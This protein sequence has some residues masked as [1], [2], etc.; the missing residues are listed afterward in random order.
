MRI[1]GTLAIFGASICVFVSVMPAR[2]EAQSESQAQ[3]QPATP[4]PEARAHYDAGMAH[5]QARAF[6]EAARAF[7]AARAIEPRPEWLFAEA[8]AT[9]L[10]G[11]CPR[12]VRLYQEF[13]ATSPPPPQVQATALALSRCERADV[14]PAPSTPEKASDIAAADSGAAVTNRVRPSYR[15][16]DGVAATAAPR[17]AGPS[18]EEVHRPVWRDPVGLG[19]ATVAAA[20]WAVTVG[21]SLAARAASR[22]A[23]AADRYQDYEPRRADAEGRARWA[24]RLALTSA[25]FTVAA[26]GRY[27]WV[28]F[29]REGGVVG[30][31]GRF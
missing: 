1:L 29:A 3:S 19:L 6:V 2:A 14:A 7:A 24:Q 20:G 28:H 17:V 16:L 26:T 12:A 21:F 10:S 27:L 5:Y 30:G 11:D 18:R 4:V 23:D 22:E 8:Q 9:R 25:A 15:V 31:G 13:L